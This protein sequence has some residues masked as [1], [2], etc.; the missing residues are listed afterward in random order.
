[1]ST[2]NWFQLQLGPLQGF[3]LHL[4][5]HVT[6]GWLS[7]FLILNFQG[8]RMHNFTCKSWKCRRETRRYPRAVKSFKS[9]KLTSF[10]FYIF[11]CWPS[12]KES[13][14]ALSVMRE[15]LCWNIQ[16]ASWTTKAILVQINICFF[17]DVNTTTFQKECLLLHVEGYQSTPCHFVIWQHEK[18]GRS[19]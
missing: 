6:L 1:M 16:L 5:E 13:P 9:V 3:C 12:V 14:K 15:T 7:D 8:S 10:F 11:L 18:T 2:H 19:Y 17:L 4:Y